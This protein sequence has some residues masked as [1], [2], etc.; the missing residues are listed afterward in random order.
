[1]LKAPEQRDPYIWEALIS[2]F[3]LKSGSKVRICLNMFDKL[4]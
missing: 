3:S 4:D 1:M 2:L